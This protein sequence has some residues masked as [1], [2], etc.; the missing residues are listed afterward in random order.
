MI[1]FA[2]CGPRRV[3]HYPFFSLWVGCL[4][5][6]TYLYLEIPDH[7]Q[8]YMTVSGVAEGPADPAVQE[9]ATQR[10]RKIGGNGAL[11]LKLS[12]PASLLYEK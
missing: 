6:L 12:A 11:K 3:S 2:P 8:L 9:G 5:V 10:G 7:C 1:E 4:P